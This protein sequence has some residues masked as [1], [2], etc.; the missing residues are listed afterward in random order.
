MTRSR[1]VPAFL[2]AFSVALSPTALTAQSEPPPSTTPQMDYPI[3]PGDLVRV[4]I[5]REE[6]LSGEFLVHQDGTV[7]LPRIGPFMAAGNTPMELREKLIAQYSET[8][9]N[10]SIDII[11]LMR[12]SIVGEVA[13]PGLY[14]VDPTMSVS[15]ALAMAGGPTSSANENKI[16]LL[17]GGDEMEV[18]LEEKYSIVDLELRSG[19]RI[20]VPEK[21]WFLRNIPLTTSIIGLVSSIVVLAFRF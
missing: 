2:L 10:P 5:W 19:D 3:R 11:P 18:D 12:V 21:N 14:P 6:D 9:R 20:Y 15:D 1:L 8:L 13:Q 7:V 17:R 16:V 4:S